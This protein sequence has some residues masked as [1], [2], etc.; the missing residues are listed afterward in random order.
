MGIIIKLIAKELAGKIKKRGYAALMVAFVCVAAGSLVFLIQYFVSYYQNQRLN[1]NLSLLYRQ[2]LRGGTDGQ[3]DDYLNEFWP[4]DFSISDGELSQA[5][6]LGDRGEFDFRDRD[7]FN[8][9][10]ERNK[11]KFAPFIETNGDFVGFIT[12]EGL[13][14]ELPF[15][16]FEDNEKYLDTNFE[17]RSS[18]YGTVFMSCYND[19]YLTDN[20]IVLF[21]H[22][23]AT[24]NMF[25]PLVGYSGIG[26]YLKAPVITLNTLVGKS[27][28]LIFAA[29][30]CEPNYGYINTWLK[31]NE[32]A[33]L[34]DEIQARS[35]FRTNVDV[36]MNDQIITLS[37]C[38]YD[39]Q[40][41]RFVVHARRLRKGE[42]K[43]EFNA[44]RNPSPKPYNV[45]DQKRL[46]DVEMRYA[47]VMRNN[48]MA[49]NYFYAR[50]E[51]GIEY[52]VG[53][54]H[55]V[56]GGYVAYSASLWEDA[57][58]TAAL[59]SDY[60]RILVAA[61]RYDGE[62]GVTLLTGSATT[63][64]G[65]LARAANNPV[66]S[67]GVDARYPLLATHEN[68][69]WLM[70]A[71][72]DDEAEILYRSR[73]YA[74]GTFEEPECVFMMKKGAELWPSGMVWFEEQCLFVWHER[75]EELLNAAWLTEGWMNF[76]GKLHEDYQ[77]AKSAQ[78][79]SSAAAFAWPKLPSY[80]C[81]LDFPEADRVTLYGEPLEDE[82]VRMLTEKD[83]RVIP[84]FLQLPPLPPETE[85]EE[86]APT[87]SDEETET[88]DEN[89]EDDEDLLDGNE[90]DEAEDGDNAAEDGEQEQGEDDG[91]G[92]DEGGDETDG[93]EKTDNGGETDG[94]DSGDGEDAAWDGGEDE[95]GDESTE[96]G[97]DEG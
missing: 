41:A 6:L 95:S 20:N 47:G 10:I 32:F 94:G 28:W 61:G 66:T 51:R 56:Q 8:E 17:G 34:L 89:G 18:K 80:F 97:E 26:T 83:G 9:A 87:P 86:P 27:E 49:R 69:I 67:E 91:Q 70:Y 24:G 21:G 96:A 64:P 50:T 25:T 43:P 39:F 35:Y 90:E 4:E 15:V 93:G 81:M 82:T 52:Y 57:V 72:C 78:K 37:T 58:V 76:F 71:V 63:T 2:A 19:P 40:D 54:T 77:K 48:R 22:H 88:E 42:T 62:G 13:G 3:G 33:D 44:E 65:P 84:G 16:H 1:D 75:E 14:V 29:Y 73:I 59:T 36:N 30:V 92:H 23:T 74:D 85:E 45:P 68:D 79:N 31:G 38:T 11:K 46:S 7:L 55:S 60:N 5:M 53:S 12:I